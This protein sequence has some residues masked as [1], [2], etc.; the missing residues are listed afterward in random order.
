MDIGRLHVYRHN[1]KAYRLYKKLGFDEIK[2][3]GHWI[4]AL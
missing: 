2:S 3:I 1:E 4:K